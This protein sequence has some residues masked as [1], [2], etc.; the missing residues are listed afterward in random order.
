MLYETWLYVLSESTLEK[1]QDLR[2]LRREWR[3]AAMW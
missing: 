1:P 3:N 2:H